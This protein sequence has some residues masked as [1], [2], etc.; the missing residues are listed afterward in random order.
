M[1]CRDEPGNDSL[2]RQLRDMIEEF[3]LSLEG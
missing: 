1:D 3:G 2:L